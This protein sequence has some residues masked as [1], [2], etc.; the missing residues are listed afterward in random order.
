MARGSLCHGLM[1]ARA[2]GGSRGFPA[3]T[4]DL[5][6]DN[7]ILCRLPPKTSVK[8]ISP[9]LCFLNS[10]CLLS[11]PDA[12]LGVHPAFVLSVACRMFATST[13]PVH[14]HE[15]VILTPLS[16]NFPLPGYC[17][18][19]YS[20][21]AFKYYQNLGLKQACPQRDI[22]TGIRHSS[23]QTDR[24]NAKRILYTNHLR[25][26]RPRVRSRDDDPVQKLRTK[27]VKQ[28]QLIA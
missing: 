25:I 28:N 11:F 26:M 17:S 21:Y 22:L 8:T 3:Y 7:T 10:I 12:F 4:S 16:Y 19:S 13:L 2:A 9:F 18:S 14:I 5:I 6:H 24:G 23:C 15:L 20:R 1:T 27:K